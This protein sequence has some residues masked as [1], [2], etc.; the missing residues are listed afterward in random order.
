LDES[1]L[2]M[3]EF[4]RKRNLV[5][6]TVAAWRSEQRRHRAGFVEV[7]IAN[8]NGSS[9]VSSVANSTDRTLCAELLLPGGMMLR[10]F[11]RDTGAF[12]DEEQV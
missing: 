11:G 4:C 10:I 7:E 9:E 2:S 3:A 5:Y 6:G 8:D 1:G 12:A